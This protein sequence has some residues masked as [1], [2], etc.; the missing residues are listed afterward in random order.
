MANILDYL[1]WRGDIPFSYRPLCEIDALIFSQLSYLNLKN[2]VPEDFDRKGLT[3]REVWIKFK[4]SPD[5][6]DRCNLGSQINPLTVDLLESAA[7]SVRFGSL[8]VSGYMDKVDESKEEQFACLTFRGDCNWNFIA[9]RG[10]DDSFLGWKEDFNMAYEDK[11]PAQDDA[12]DYLEKSVAVLRGDF[13]LGGHSKGGNLA[14]YSAVKASPKT[15]KRIAGVFN[16]DGPGFKKEFFITEDYLEIKNKVHSF[17]PE[18]SIVGMLFDHA[19]GYS[20]VR[21]CERNMIKQH[22]PFGWQLKSRHFEE[23]AE[24][25]EQ[26]YFAASTVNG[27]LSELNNEEKKLFIETIFGILKDTEVKTNQELNADLAE[28]MIKML[29]SASKLD[30]KTRESVRKTIQVLFKLAWDNKDELKG[31]K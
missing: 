15:K 13:Y 23:L 14:L 30:S 8:I 31:K 4:N 28:N 21:S 27:L 11:I 9:Y 18:L 26:S 1:D 24:R 16:N 19:P 12:L 6:K 29:K 22:D 25:S 2:I 20:I 17:V 5:Y 10:T 3:L 7:S